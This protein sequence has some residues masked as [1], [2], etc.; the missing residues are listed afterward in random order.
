VRPALPPWFTRD[1]AQAGSFLLLPL[2]IGGRAVGFFYADR[3]MVDERGL[4]P[5]E[6]NLLRALRNQI[7]LAMRAR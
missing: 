3:P 4:S 1:F 5:E 6:L 7:V 2:A